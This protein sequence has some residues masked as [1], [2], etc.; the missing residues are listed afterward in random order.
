MLKATERRNGTYMY[1]LYNTT[2]RPAALRQISQITI[3]R[4]VF[5]Y[6]PIVIQTTDPDLVMTE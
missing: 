5:Q 6:R 3:S 2:T 4:L 1:R